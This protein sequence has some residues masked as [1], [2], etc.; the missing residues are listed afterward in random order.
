MSGE[1]AVGEAAGAGTAAIEDSQN[2]VLAV[3]GTLT[4]RAADLAADTVTKDFVATAGSTATAAFMVEVVSTEAEEASTAEA[5][6]V[7][8]AVVAP[9]VA[10]AFTA[11][12]DMEAGTAAGATSHA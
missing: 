9:T 6:V 11:V 7:S 10:E 4:G 1:T 12:G 8:M 2:A 5:V 3:A